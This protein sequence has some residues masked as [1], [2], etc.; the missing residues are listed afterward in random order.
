MLL[1][2][3]ALIACRNKF[4]SEHSSSAGGNVI[5]TERKEL[6]DSNTSSPSLVT[7]DGMTMLV[8]DVQSIKAREPIDV[9]D[10]GMTI[11]VSDIH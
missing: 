11:F 6:H 8:I 1:G 9:T 5:S 3:I 4:G 10:V 7:E 2:V